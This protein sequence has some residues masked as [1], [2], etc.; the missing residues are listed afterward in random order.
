MLERRLKQHVPDRGHNRVDPENA[1]FRGVLDEPLGR[2]DHVEFGDLLN[3]AGPNIRVLDD[4]VSGE[5]HG[6]FYTSLSVSS[7]LQKSAD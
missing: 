3:N 1:D 2:L 5:I 4:V 6:Q 7:A